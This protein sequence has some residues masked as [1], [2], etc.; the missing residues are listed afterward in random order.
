MFSRTQAEHAKHLDTVL[1]LLG[2]G[3][4]SLKLKK[5]S[6]FQPKVQY[7]G[8][9]I[10]TGKLSVAHTTAKSFKTFAFPRTLT[11]VRLFLGRAT[12]IAASLRASRR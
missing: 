9:V 8:H 6:F 2:S 10:S 5:C 4:I 1:S 3:G 12:S 7:L 11:Q